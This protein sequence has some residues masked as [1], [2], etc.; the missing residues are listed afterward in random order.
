MIFGVSIAGLLS[1]C[2]YFRIIKLLYKIK[3]ITQK[4]A[5]KKIEEKISKDDLIELNWFSKSFDSM[6]S[7]L[8]NFEKRRRELMSDLTHELRTPLT[9]VRGS[10]EGLA[11]ES[12]SS[13]PEP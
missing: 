6:T 9:V 13:S 1:Y 3:S 10:L 7:S 12:I 8:E 5:D 11:N 4:P 2:I